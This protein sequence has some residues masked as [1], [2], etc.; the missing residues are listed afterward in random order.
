[1][2]DLIGGER[3]LPLKVTSQAAS[4]RLRQHAPNPGGALSPPFITAARCPAPRQVPGAFQSRSSLI[5]AHTNLAKARSHAW[6][7]ATEP[8][9]SFGQRPATPSALRDVVPPPREPRRV[10]DP[11]GPAP[12]RCTVNCIHIAKGERKEGGGHGTPPPHTKHARDT[13]ARSE[14]PTSTRAPHP[15]SYTCVP[16]C[17]FFF[18]AGS[19]NEMDRWPSRPRNTTTSMMHAR[20]LHLTPSS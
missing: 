11:L 1:M 8:C 15:S 17:S 3:S 13:S 19:S 10:T 9:D 14:R 20:R 2:P 12:C 5:L 18:M 4:C 16:C 6:T 7:H